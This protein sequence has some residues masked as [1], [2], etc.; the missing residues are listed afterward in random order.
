MIK[1]YG[2]VSPALAS[3]QYTFGGPLT[4]LPKII[5]QPDRNWRP[6]LPAYEPQFNEF[7]DS[8]GCTVYGTENAIETLEKKLFG[9]EPNYSERFIYILSKIVPPGGDPH[10]VAEV[11]RQ[12]G[13]ITDQLLPMVSSFNDFL[14][15][16]PMSREFL[17][18]GTSWPYEFLHE[19]VWVNSPPKEIRLILIREALQYSPLAVS[20]TA[21]REEGGFY[22]DQGR[23][24][25]HWCVLFALDGDAPLIFDTYDQSI[26]R[27]HPDHHIE[28]CKRYSITK[29]TVRQGWVSVVLAY[30]SK[31][32]AS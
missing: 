28:V 3:D 15:P 11:I 30:F 4:K 6:F 32:G 31:I 1:D 27:L 20:V 2:Y 5:L 14:K 7:F 17:K 10:K 29:K 24:N 22:V 12:H 13:L 18:E 21:W 9:G 19:W 8:F 16:N 25:T 23:P 26:K